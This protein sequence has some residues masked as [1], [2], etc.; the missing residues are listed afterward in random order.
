MFNPD[1][2][3]ESSK[4]DL[5]GRASFAQSFSNALLAHKDKASIVTALYGDWGTGKSSV[6]NMAVESIKDCT[7]DL[8][9][10]KK[11]IIIRFNPWN[12][13]DQNQ[14]VSEFFKELSFAIRREDTSEN[15]KTVGEKL[16]VYSNF[17]IPLSLIPEPTVS[18]SLLL[19]SKVFKGVGKAAKSWGATHGKDLLATKND[20]TELLGIQSRKLLIIID[21][22]DRLLNSYHKCIT[23]I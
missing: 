19:L 10:D 17:F 14:L 8:Y 12:Y 18:L 15:A 3:I 4:E 20:L 23:S 6:I 7:R 1:K 21:D 16:E 13:S 5:L 11:P 22:I 9:R 2:P